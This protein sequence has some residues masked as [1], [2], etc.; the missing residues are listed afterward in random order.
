MLVRHLPR[1]SRVTVRVFDNV[2][3]TDHGMYDDKLIC[4][5]NPVGCRQRFQVLLFFLIYAKYQWL[6]NLIVRRGGRNTSE[7]WVDAKAAI[8]RARSKRDPV[9]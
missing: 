8:G 4:S 9:F 5:H 1:G 3:L 2:G 6:L 7:G